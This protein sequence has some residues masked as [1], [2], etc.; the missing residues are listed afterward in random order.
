MILKIKKK[1]NLKASVQQK[2]KSGDLIPSSLAWNNATSSLYTKNKPVD[3]T[4]QEKT[5]SKPTFGKNNK[6]EKMTKIFVN[7]KYKNEH[8]KIK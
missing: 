5:H 7:L 8:S 2:K 6:P 3:K 1:I 4:L